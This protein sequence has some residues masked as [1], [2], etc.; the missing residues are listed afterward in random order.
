MAALMH[1]ISVGSLLSCS[2]RPGMMIGVRVLL[3][4]IAF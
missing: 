3:A 1:D 4:D 2:T